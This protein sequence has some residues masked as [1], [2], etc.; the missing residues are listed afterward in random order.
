MEHV[1]VL[2]IAGETVKA[3]G[4]GGKIVTVQVI[5]GT[6]CAYMV[7]LGLVPIRGATPRAAH[8]LEVVT[9]IAQLAGQ[10]TMTV[11]DLEVEPDIEIEEKRRIGF[12]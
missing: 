1:H 8:D 6:P 9:A 5:N 10:A 4:R 12:V 11:P 7:G 3:K 2:P